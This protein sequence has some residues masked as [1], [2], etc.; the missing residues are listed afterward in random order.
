[1]ELKVL[2][3]L[4]MVL[5]VFCD[6]PPV[7]TTSQGRITG[8]TLQF[9]PVVHPELARDVD[10]YL[11]IPYAEP[12]VGP[13]RFK[14]PVAKSWSG[15]LKATKLGNRCPQPK[16]PFGLNLVISGPFDE[17]CLTID[18]F[19]PRPAPHKAAVILSVH[20][21]G[22]ILGAGTMEELMPSPLVAVGGVIVVAFNY[23]IGA[24]GFLSTNDDVIPGN[25]GMLDQKLAMEW[26]RDNIEAFGGDPNRV[27]IAGV[28][29]GSSSVGLHMVSPASA[30]LFRGAIMESGSGSAYWASMSSEKARGRAFALGKLVGC[31]QETSQELL[32]CLQRVENGDI[33]VENQHLKLSEA[34]GELG[35]TFFSPVYDDGT[36]LTEAVPDL[37]AKGAINDAASIIGANADEGMFSV[38]SF[39]PNVTHE[40]APFIDAATYAAL[41][42]MCTYELSTEPIVNKAVNMMYTDATCADRK[43]C[44]YLQSLSQLCGDLTFVCPADYSARAH[45]N[46]GR[47]VYRYHMTHHPANPV[48]G[49]A[50]AG[51]NHGEEMTYVYGVPLVPSDKIKYPDEEMRMSLRMIRYWSNFAKTGDPN[52]S[53]LDAALTDE[54]KK[55]EWPLFTV[56]GLEYKELTPEMQNGRGIKAQ[57]CRFWNDFIPELLET[58]EEA[59]KGRAGSSSYGDGFGSETCTEE[60]CPED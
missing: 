11:G 55:T 8:T 22:Y 30:G 3:V 2:C 53:S 45:V 10:A 36:F 34:L 31:E 52:L 18:V 39:L 5:E 35:F 17:D 7:V 19:V 16:V 14:A 29:A 23:R 32:E 51:A 46:A 9:R 38:M 56:E 49:P 27:T 60:T 50:W 37:Y 40:E 59:K 24:L 41:Q 13:L 4:C 44:N 48:L 20:G 54:E 47:K 26:V 33:F 1:M 25:M 21:G 43:D 42:P 58:I 6:D 15:E 12:P 57:E 28:S